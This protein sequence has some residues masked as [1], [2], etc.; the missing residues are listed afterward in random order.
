VVIE[1]DPRL[2]SLFARSFPTATVRPQTTDAQLAQLRVR[3]FDVSSPA[4]SLPRFFR[5]HV[6]DFP[7]HDGFL[8]PD[9]AR[10][11]AWRARLASVP[12]PRVGITWRSKLNTSERRLEY[13]RLPEWK[14]IFAVR[15]VS[16]VNLQYDD[17][18]RDLHDAERRFGITIHRWPDV[19]YMNDFEEVA[20]L[21]AALD[22]VVAPRNAVAMLA[23]GLGVPTVMMGNRRDWSDVG[24]DRCPWL[25]S[26]TLVAR[27]VDEPWD[28]VLA[29]ALARVQALV[30]TSVTPD[31]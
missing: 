5:R 19:D 30:T 10:V 2:A 23:G 3:D 21:M 6:G 22:L 7:D 12:A 24:L 25:P 27:E 1:T 14:D 4:G 17:C 28:N 18:E 26:I 16:F 9:P 15:G 11:D 31:S 8:V 13:T 20:A 29:T